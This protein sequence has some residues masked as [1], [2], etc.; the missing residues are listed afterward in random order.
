[1]AAEVKEFY[2]I[3][4]VSMILNVIPLEKLTGDSYGPT[5]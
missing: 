2:K 4:G 5:G 3:L 1:M